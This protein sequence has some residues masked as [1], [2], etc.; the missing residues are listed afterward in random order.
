MSSILNLALVDDSSTDT[1]R[2]RS[3]PRGPLALKYDI[4]LELDEL[5]EFALIQ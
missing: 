5:S 3:P 4:K 2:L 1:E